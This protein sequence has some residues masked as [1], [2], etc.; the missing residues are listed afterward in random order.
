MTTEQFIQKNKA[1]L[2]AILKTDIPLKLAV[3]SVVGMQ[4]KR[5]FQDGKNTANAG[6]GSYNATDPLYVNTQRNAPINN[7]VR[8]KSGESKFKNGKPHKTTYYNSYKDFRQKQK[9]EAGFVNLRLT[10]ELQS[11]FSNAQISTSSN[12]VATANPIKVNVHYYK[13]ELKK[14]IN[15]KKRE[16]LEKKYGT[17]FYLTKEEKALFL[18]VLTNELK[19]ALTVNA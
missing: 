9:R 17:I 4:A 14:P 7:P 1:A 11:D 2:E 18:T 6:I 5:I 19:A 13:T 15:Q 12:K 16:G 10:N 8:G 3:Y